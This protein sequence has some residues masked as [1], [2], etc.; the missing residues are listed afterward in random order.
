MPG[1]RPSFAQQKVLDRIIAGGRLSFDSSTGRYQLLE[2]GQIN[3]VDQR[4]VLVMLRNGL[5][6]QDMSGICRLN[7]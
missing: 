4:P 6:F 2:Q 1:T 7:Y 3:S 5:L